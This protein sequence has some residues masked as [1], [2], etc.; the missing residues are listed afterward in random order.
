MTD[1]DN[2]RIWTRSSHHSNH[3]HL[4]CHITTFTPSPP[5]LTSNYTARENVC[6]SDQRSSCP[7]GFRFHQLE[8]IRCGAGETYGREMYRRRR[9][10]QS[11]RCSRQEDL[12]VTLSLSSSTSPWYSESILICSLAQV[13]SWRTSIKVS[14]TARSPHSSSVPPM[15][16]YS[17]KSERPRRSHS[18]IC[19]RIRAAPTRWTTLSRRRSTKTNSV[20]IHLQ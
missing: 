14:S 10:R 19:G 13:I 1:R 8:R 16:N 11:Y 5:R 6:E 3:L 2:V 4:F 20:R 7:E 17:Y 15:V 9:E 18:P 12:Y